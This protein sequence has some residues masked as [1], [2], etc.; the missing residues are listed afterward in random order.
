MN[1]MII[2]KS[3]I[4]EIVIGASFFLV[5]ILSLFDEI[6]PTDFLR[7][8]FGLLF[9]ITGIFTYTKNYQK[10]LYQLIM[11]VILVSMLILFYRFSLFE[12]TLISI[13]LGLLALLFILGMYFV[14]REWENFQK[15][16]EKHDEIM[17]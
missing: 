17:E 15:E 10:N 8:F 6:R 11:T 1:L 2:T 3:G 7:L 13:F 9:I 5:F 4:V 14:P 12:D 16:L